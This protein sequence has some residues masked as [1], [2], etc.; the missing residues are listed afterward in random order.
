MKYLA[1]TLD[2]RNLGQVLIADNG[3]IFAVILEIIRH[4][5]ARLVTIVTSTGSFDFDYNEEVETSLS[6]ELRMLRILMNAVE[7]LEDAVAEQ[8][9]VNKEIVV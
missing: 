3:N 4:P 9:H 5:E 2:E 8:P 7:G 1:H 6:S